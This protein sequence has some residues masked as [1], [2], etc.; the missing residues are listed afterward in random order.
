MV[1]SIHMYL[2]SLVA[3]SVLLIAHGNKVLNIV[4]A[5]TLSCWERNRAEKHLHFFPESFLCF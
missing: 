5:K 2:V 4:V 1:L 3:Q